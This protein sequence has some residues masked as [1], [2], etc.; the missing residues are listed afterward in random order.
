MDIRIR[1]R[2][3]VRILELDGRLSLGGGAA[4]VREDVRQQLEDGHAM[5]LLDMSQV[6]AIDSTGLGVLVSCL[7]SVRNRGG[8]LRLLQPTPRVVDVLVITQADLL[9]EIFDNE[10]LAVQSFSS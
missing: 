2:D 3:Q 6:D 10:D 9:F 8:D 4:A 5:L 1:D 7:T